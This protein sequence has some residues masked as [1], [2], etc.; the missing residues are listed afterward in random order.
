MIYK[1]RNKQNNSNIN[2]RTHHT[3]NVNELFMSV[4]E[5]KENLINRLKV[6]LENEIYFD[7]TWLESEIISTAGLNTLPTQSISISKKSKEYQLVHTH[8]NNLNI[9]TFKTIH[10]LIINIQLLLDI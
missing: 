2:I 4:Y 1:I 9:Y 7:L 10:A 5:T 8:K 3:S 6:Y